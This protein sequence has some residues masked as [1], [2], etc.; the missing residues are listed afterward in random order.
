MKEFIYEELRQV[1]YDNKKIHV[2]QLVIA[3]AMSFITILITGDDLVIFTKELAKSLNLLKLFP[4]INKLDVQTFW[5]IFL[6][7]LSIAWA[8]DLVVE[9]S[10]KY[11]KELYRSLFL[12][13]LYEND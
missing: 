3:F 2:F 7:P 5:L 8:R 4:I 6:F 9:V 13:E 11:S 10:Q 12:I 1:D